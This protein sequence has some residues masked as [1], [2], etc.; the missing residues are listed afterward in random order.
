VTI[1]GP[2]T[3]TKHIY[4]S[5]HPPHLHI[6]HRPTFALPFQGRSAQQHRGPNQPNPS[7][8]AVLVRDTS[9]V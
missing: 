7:G 2:P 6:L 1:S 9:E 5:S 8:R 3:S 4:T